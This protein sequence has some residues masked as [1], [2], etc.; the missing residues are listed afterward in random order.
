M[1]AGGEAVVVAVSDGVRPEVVGRWSL[2]LVDHRNRPELA[3]PYHAAA[4]VLGIEAGRERIRL[5]EQ[6]AREA[7]DSIVDTVLSDL[8]RDRHRPSSAGLVLGA[9][10]LAGS[11]EEILRSHVQL[12]TAEGELLRTALGDAAAARGLHVVGVGGRDLR[13][14][15]CAVAELHEPELAGRLDAFGR[16]LGPPWTKRE[17]SACLVAWAALAEP[18]PGARP[19]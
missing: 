16:S 17:K 8:S 6:A 2:C 11:L 5:C 3:Q 19:K 18:T 12:H 13:T 7:A 9:G 1:H 15:V 14:R 10:R 4:E